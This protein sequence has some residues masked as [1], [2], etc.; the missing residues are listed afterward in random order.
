MITLLHAKQQYPIQLLCEV[1]YYPRSSFYYRAH[2]RDDTAARAAIA[3]AQAQWPTYGYRRITV[4][5]R[6]GRAPLNSKRG[7]LRRCSARLL[8]DTFSAA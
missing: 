8:F 4:E 2:P 6:R 1:L 3:E 5:A 7:R